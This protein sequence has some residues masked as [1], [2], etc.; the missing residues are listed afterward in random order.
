MSIGWMLPSKSAPP[1]GV[2]A[3]GNEDL[4]EV[5]SGPFYLYAGVVGGGAAT[6]H[7]SWELL[8]EWDSG[9]PIVTHPTS[10][11]ARIDLWTE[12]DWMGSPAPVGKG[13]LTLTADGH[14]ETLTAAFMYGTGSYGDIALTS[15]G[16]EGGGG[17]GG[18]GGGPG[19]IFGDF[20]VHLADGFTP[21]DQ[22]IYARPAMGTGHSRLRRMRRP[23]LPEEMQVDRTVD[24]AWLL[25][26]AQMEQFEDTFERA[27]KAGSEPFCVPVK[28]Q[29][30]ADINADAISWW[31]AK[32]AAPPKAEPRKGG[33]WLYS[34][35]L[36]MLSRLPSD[37]FARTNP[38]QASLGIALHATAQPVMP[39]PLALELSL[40]LE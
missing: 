37:L 27:L 6:W 39:G 31:A 2:P 28:R 17:G 3:H 4:I 34:G 21:D 10:D 32:W 24:I 9:T 23:L 38:L 40:P 11:V 7:W 13:T 5:W 15:E 16:E 29:D 18:G 26:D 14:P 25:T 1:T 19:V 22:D 33:R 35:R 30:S 8:Y 12:L 36:R 20:I